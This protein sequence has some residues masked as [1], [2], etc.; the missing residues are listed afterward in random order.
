MKAVVVLGCEGRQ[1]DGF[2]FCNGVENI[3]VD[4]EKIE[5]KENS[6]SV[7]HYRI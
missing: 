4:L 5:S 1:D 2:D 7:Y 6:G 3:I